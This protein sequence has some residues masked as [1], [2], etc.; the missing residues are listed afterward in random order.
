MLHS[1]AT[2]YQKN[3]FNHHDNHIVKPSSILRNKH[4]LMWIYF[5]FSHTNKTS[6]LNAIDNLP[7]PNGGTFVVPALNLLTSTVYTTAE[8]DRPDVS[9]TAII[10]TDGQPSES[11]SALTDAINKV[12]NQTIRTLVV[13]VTTNINNETLRLLSSPPQ[14]VITYFVLF[15]LFIMRW[16][17]LCLIVHTSSYRQ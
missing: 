17:G 12:H 13:G 7:Y 16:L 10:I 6:L 15:V 1:S 4:F 9:D 14:K 3:S 8:G 11:M 2:I 5:R